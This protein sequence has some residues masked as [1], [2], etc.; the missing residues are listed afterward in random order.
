MQWLLYLLTDS[1]TRFCL[2]APFVS[3]RCCL[4]G[5][6]L[7]SWRKGIRPEKAGD[8]RG[9]GKARQDVTGD[10]RF[11]KEL[12]EQDE[13]CKRINSLFFHLKLH[14]LESGDTG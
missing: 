9:S 11:V 5:E 7:T 3:P 12:R 4:Q 1:V 6:T 10:E 8:Y 13:M 2:R 14:T